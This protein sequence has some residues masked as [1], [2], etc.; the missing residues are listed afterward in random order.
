MQIFNDVNIGVDSKH[1]LANKHKYYASYPL[2]KKNGKKRLISAP[3]K[4][5]KLV[6][7]AFMDCIEPFVERR[8]DKS[9]VGFRKRKSTIDNAVHH[10]NKL[11]LVN[12]D[13]KDFFP[14]IPSKWLREEL[15]K[16]FLK[17]R[18]RKFKAVTNLADIDSNEMFEFLTLDGKLPQGSPCSPMLA[19]LYLSD[20]GFD[21]EM[22]TI[23]GWEY[24]RY[25]DDLSFSTNNDLT[26]YN[27]LNGLVP[28]V[29]GEL[30]KRQLKPSIK[31]TTIK[32]FDQ[33]QVVTGLLVNGEN[34]KI[35]R[36]VANNVRAALHQNGLNDKNKGFLSY[37]NSVSKE[38]CD[39]LIKSV[40]TGD[41][42]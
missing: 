27:I 4:Q 13:I 19:N 3:K 35:P 14:S 9:V 34:P 22:S 21:Q 26:K 15:K 33:K 10:L 25:A 6:Q 18:I 31:K 2:I 1:F 36:R 41:K 17:P 23:T 40:K 16:F 7:R 39:K 37:T 42:E 24:S 12:I 5:L 28:Y 30:E 29:Y 20:T 8:L 11:I 32:R 38:Q